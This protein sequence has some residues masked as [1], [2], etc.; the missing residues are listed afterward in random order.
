MHLLYVATIVVKNNE[1][2]DK[3]YWCLAFLM[4]MEMFNKNNI[5]YGQPNI[6]NYLPDWASKKK[7]KKY[8]YFFQSNPLNIICKIL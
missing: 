1:T 6:Q 2:N 7:Q 8:Y 5:Y 3:F 4:Y